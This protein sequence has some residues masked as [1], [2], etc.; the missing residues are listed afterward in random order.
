MNRRTAIG[1]KRRPVSR[2]DAER[3]LSGLPPGSDD[4]AQLGSALGAMR[5]L[6]QAVP[7]EDE[8][9]AFAAQAAKLVPPGEERLAARALPAAGRRRS[10]TRLRPALVSAIGTIALL[11]VASA[12]VAYAANGAVPGDPLYDLDIALEKIG[13]G[14][15]GLQE[16]L[17]EAGRLVDKGELEA[18][19]NHAGDAVGGLAVD[20]QSLRAV[21]EALWDS[22]DAAARGEG[23]QTAEGRGLVAERLRDMASLEPRSVEFGQAVDDLGATFSGQGQPDGDPGTQTPGGDQGTTGTTQGYATT[24]TSVGGGTGGGPGNGGGSGPGH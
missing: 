20:E 16:R 2:A 10:R 18:G 14:D 6:G 5:S 15:G 4:A 22:A 1:G 17:L 21:A 8:V 12:G 13:L 3:L 19:L 11:L 24:S 9:R 7:S 23:P